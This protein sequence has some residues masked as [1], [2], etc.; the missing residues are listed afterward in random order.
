MLYNFPE[1]DANR[2]VAELQKQLQETQIELD[3]L[4]QATDVG[5]S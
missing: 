3:R 4:K 5:V 1:T 2:V